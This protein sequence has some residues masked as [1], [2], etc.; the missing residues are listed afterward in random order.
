M[1]PA[2]ESGWGHGSSWRSL[3]AIARRS[4]GPGSSWPRSSSFPSFWGSV[5]RWP[6]HPDAT[7]GAGS[8]HR[9]ERSDRT[10]GHKS[11]GIVIEQPARAGAGLPRN[12]LRIPSLP[13]QGVLQ[14][15]HPMKFLVGKRR[16]VS[17]EQTAMFFRNLGE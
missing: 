15:K 1:L 13:S 16:I 2:T 8:G 9:D 12:G 4:G 14:R 7:N 3:E 6:V 11:L 17:A 10:L 5:F